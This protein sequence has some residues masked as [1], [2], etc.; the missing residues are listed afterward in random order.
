MAWGWAWG[1]SILF[2]SHGLCAL[3]TMQATAVKYQTCVLP[4]QEVMLTLPWT[5]LV[6]QVMKAQGCPES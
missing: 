1:I 2:S 6:T 5:P 3:W 4:V